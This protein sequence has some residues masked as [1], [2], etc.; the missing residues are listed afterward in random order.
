M[1]LAGRV[2]LVVALAA[3]AHGAGGALQHALAGTAQSSGVGLVGV[4]MQFEHRAV[5]DT[6]GD[7]AQHRAARRVERDLDL[8]AV[9]DTEPPRIGARQVQVAARNDQT[10]GAQGPCRAR[11][12]DLGAAREI[13]GQAQRRL[14]AEPDGLGAADLDLVGRTAG[15]DDAH[16]FEPAA[17]AEETVSSAAKKPGWLSGC[18]TRSAWPVPNKASTAA[19]VSGVEPP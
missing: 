2:V 13:A 11:Q 12:R 19:C 1:R 4:Q 6:Q 17:L 14:D 9:L 7:M 10:R 8:P 16:A 15:P 3:D 18:N 5:V